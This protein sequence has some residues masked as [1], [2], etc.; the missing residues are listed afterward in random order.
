VT[1]GSEATIVRNV[2]VERCT[3]RGPTVLR[4]KLRPDTA[5]QYENIHLHDITLDG[6]GV[7]FNVAPWKQYFDLKGQPPPK[8]LVR[9]ITISDM[10]GSG[11]SFGKIIG[12]P[13]TE[14]SD[15][16]VKDVDVKLKNT[17]FGGQGVPP[18]GT[19]LDTV[20]PLAKRGG[21]LHRA[22]AG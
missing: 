6:A 13:D 18:F 19:G 21:P 2:D 15:I 14:I 17:K 8:S 11:G 1:A 16:A 22:A 3:T 5:Q 10:K 4:L 20:N 12:N 9:N 7:I